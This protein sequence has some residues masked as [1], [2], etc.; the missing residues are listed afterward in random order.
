MLQLGELCYLFP[1]KATILRALFCDCLYS[2]N[3]PRSDLCFTYSYNVPHSVLPL[4]VQLQLGMLLC[5]HEQ[6]Q[7]TAI[8]FVY[9]Y[10][11][12]T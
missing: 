12:T 2:Y 9:A 4:F 10:V 3:L 1:R 8:R 7:L 5:L 6:L 11:A